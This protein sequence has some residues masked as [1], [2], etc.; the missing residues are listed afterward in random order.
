MG[1]CESPS[2]SAEGTGPYDGGGE[3]PTRHPTS[4]DAITCVTTL[5]GAIPEHEQ[6]A[7]LR[8]VHVLARLSAKRRRAILALTE[9]EEGEER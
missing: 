7:V 8:H 9:A 1:S 2:Q 6:E 5:L 4:Y 3:G